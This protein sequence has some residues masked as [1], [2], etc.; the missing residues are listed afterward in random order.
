MF[1]PTATIMG[2]GEYCWFLVG[3]TPKTTFKLLKVA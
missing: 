1:F 2:G 3:V